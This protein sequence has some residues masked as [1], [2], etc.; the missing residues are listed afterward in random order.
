MISDIFSENELL[1]PTAKTKSGDKSM[2]TKQEADAETLQPSWAALQ[3]EVSRLTEALAV[4]QA[5]YQA[6]VE[7]LADVVLVT[8][9]AGHLVQIAGNTMGILGYTPQEIMELPPEGRLSCLRF[10]PDDMPLLQEKW[11]RA[12]EMPSASQFLARIQDRAGEYRWTEIALT[13]IHDAKEQLI[14]VHGVI[15]DVNDRVHGEQFMRSLNAIAETIQHTPLSVAEVM[16]TTM[17]QL[18]TLDLVAGILLLDETATSLWGQVG[19]DIQAIEELVGLSR[20]ELRISLDEAPDLAPVLAQ[21]QTLYLIVNEGLVAQLLPPPKR[22]FAKAIAQILSSFRAIVTPL[23]AN[24]QQFGLLFV[25]GAQVNS[26]NRPAIVSLAHQTAIAIRNAQLLQELSASEAQYRG[27]FEEAGDGLIVLSQEGTII[28]A[29]PAACALHGLNRAEMVGQAMDALLH[30]DARQRF[31]EGLKQGRQGEHFFGELTAIRSDGTAV[32]VEVRGGPLVYRGKPHLL[33]VLRDIS[34]RV[35]A[36]EAL[37]HAEKLRAL[38]QMAGGIA[39]DFNNILVS[40]RGYADMALLDLAEAPE[41]V[42]EDLQRILAGANDAAEA[43]RRLQA[44]YRQADDTSDFVTVHL[45]ALVQEALALSQPRWK[46]QA[47]AQGISIRIE[48]ECTQPAP[49]RGN[50]S[51]LRRVLLNLISNAIEAMPQGGT[52]KLCTR[53]EGR[54]SAI[55]VADTG[56]GIPTEVLPKIFEPFFTT[57]GR[58]G[59]GLGLTISQSIVH[60][61]GG[62]IRVESR[63]GEGACF[64]V[65]LPND[66]PVPGQAGAGAPTAIPAQAPGGASALVVDDDPGVR[67]LLQRL[68]AREGYQVTAVESGREALALLAERTFNLLI[69]DL[70]MPEIPGDRVVHYARQRYPQLPIILATGWGET[71]SPEQMQEMGASALLP[72]P[73]THEELHQALAR[74]REGIAQ[75]SI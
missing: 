33:L 21:G 72:K 65:W 36:Q 66:Q 24:N 28:E 45:D 37:V 51:E 13:P 6:L 16:E 68:L 7:N 27:I 41:L 23:V 60:R 19:G 11:C 53:Q 18:A 35:R 59:T 9:A 2:E 70:G 22:R 55:S 31:Q 56:V 15:R 64:T 42:R 3:D 43:V 12:R 4:L 25:A 63:P 50:P 54:W 69:S 38:G 52:L 47:Q 5:R 14:G 62:E 39:H 75:E 30:D 46:D 8:D 34:E 61:H 48:T 20:H 1:P 26:A 10:H 74:A 32:P 40:I 73:F 71:V 17:G 58:S 49:I 57:K 44:L 29:N 67:A